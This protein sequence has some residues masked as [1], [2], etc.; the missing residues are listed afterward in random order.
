MTPPHY[1]YENPKEEATILVVAPSDLHPGFQFVASYEE[2]AF[3]VTGKRGVRHEIY[4]N[5]FAIAFSRCHR[6]H[7]PSIYSPPFSQGRRNIRGPSSRYPKEY[8][9][10]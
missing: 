9:T 10:Q 4:V 2:G 6:C 1:Q 3:V 8:A 7:S 5:R